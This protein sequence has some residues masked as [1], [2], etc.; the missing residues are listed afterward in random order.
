MQDV[1]ESLEG[2]DRVP[3]AILSDQRLGEGLSGL[4]VIEALREQL[5]VAVPA[6]LIS[7]ESAPDSSRRSL[8]MRLSEADAGACSRMSFLSAWPSTWARPQSITYTSPKRPTMMFA[9]F[10]SRWITFFECA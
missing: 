6:A 3:D 7:G 8:R 4:E 10:R 1:L 2:T 5:G 9:G